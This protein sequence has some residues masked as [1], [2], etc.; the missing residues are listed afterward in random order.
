[1]QKLRD[2]NME[3]QGGFLRIFIAPHS[4]T[5]G[6]MLF[7]IVSIVISFKWENANF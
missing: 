7:I 5:L 2:I 1:M 3:E 4:F 6:K